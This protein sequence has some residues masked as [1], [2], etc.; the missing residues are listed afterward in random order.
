MAASAIAALVI[1]G[2]LGIYAVRNLEEALQYS[3]KKAIPSI[4]L[5]YR[6]SAL[7]RHIRQRHY[8]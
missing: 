6:A 5:I 4:Q 2:G 1:V 3:N 8:T 7:G